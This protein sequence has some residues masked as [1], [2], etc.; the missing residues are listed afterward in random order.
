MHSLLYFLLLIVY[1]NTVETDAFIHEISET[2]DDSKW[3]NVMRPQLRVM[4]QMQLSPGTQN[5]SR[6]VDI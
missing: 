3:I 2:K 4:I 1:A 5:A 6:I